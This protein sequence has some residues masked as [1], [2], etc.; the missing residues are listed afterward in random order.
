MPDPTLK[1]TF[2]IDSSTL[3]GST[4]SLRNEIGINWYVKSSTDTNGTPQLDLYFQDLEKTMGAT[5]TYPTDWLASAK[6]TSVSERLK[7]V[8]LQPLLQTLASTDIIVPNFKVPGRFYGNKD[9]IVSDTEWKAYLMGGTFGTTTFEGIYSAATFDNY[10]FTYNLPY[11]SQEAE[12]L[13]A[14]ADSGWQSVSIKYHYNEYLPKFETWAALQGDV[15]SLPSV[16]FMEMAQSAEVIGTLAHNL[17][18]RDDQASTYDQILTVTEGPNL[19]PKNA[20]NQTITATPPNY[21]D[22]TKNLRTYLQEEVPLNPLSSETAAAAAIK[23]KNIIYGR[24]GVGPL[25]NLSSMASSEKTVLNS[26]PSY[27]SIDFPRSQFFEEVKHEGPYIRDTINDAKFSS[28]LLYL[29][30]KNF[31]DESSPTK[32]FSQYEEKHAVDAGALT[33]QKSLTGIDVKTRDLMKLLA[34]GYEEM[35][36][37]VSDCYFL[38]DEF[39][40]EVNSIRDGS[41]GSLRFLSSHSVL[42]TMTRLATFLDEEYAPTHFDSFYIDA[43]IYGKNGMYELLD[44]AQNSQYHETVAYRVEKITPTNASVIQNIWVYNEPGSVPTDPLAPFRYIDSQVKYG[45]TYTYTVYAYVVCTGVK[46][47]MADLRIGRNIGIVEPG[48]KTEQYCIQF[49]DPLTNE[50]QDQLFSTSTGEY[51]GAGNTGL[52]HGLH[53]PLADD[54]TFSSDA[55]TLSDIPYLADFNLYY[56]PTLRIFEIPIATN[57]VTILD[58]P[59]GPIDVVPFQKIDNSQEIGFL[60]KKESHEEKDPFPTVITESDQTYKDAYLDSKEI[61]ETTGITEESVSGETTLQIF[62]MTS[63]PTAYTDFANHFYKTVSLRIPDTNYYLPAYVLYDKVATNTKYYYLIRMLN[64]HNEPGPP[65]PIIEAQLIDDGGY[66]Y[67]IFNDL[68]AQDLEEDVFTNPSTSAKKLFQVVPNLNQIQLNTSGVDFNETADSQLSNI[69]LGSSTL[70]QSI[71]ESDHPLFKIRLTSKK[72]GKQIDL[73]L[74]FNL[75]QEL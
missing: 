68:F 47:R 44:D 34:E 41:Q 32:N 39:D 46:Y 2:Y 11:S 19:P 74:R 70:E 42:N 36:P 62:R 51:S 31:V 8:E 66:K 20:F 26:Y 50:V 33:P 73:N 16:A 69:T 13:A 21:V 60:I 56:E 29:L 35:D 10:G 72:T 58:N 37:D 30:K 15:K 6:S 48:K 59:A 71:F 9:K 12:E 49:H 53:N 27:V 52:Y 75:N 61:L 63:K 40:E 65:S 38:G 5:K 24:E 25:L 14:I 7:Y 3:S 23:T 54:N 57:T 45:E 22:I 4:E 1:N 67:S 17:I 64:A 28:H 43:D 55:Q 18:T